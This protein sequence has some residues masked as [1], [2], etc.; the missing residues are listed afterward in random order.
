MFEIATGCALATTASDCRGLRSQLLS[1]SAPD[2]ERSLMRL[3]LIEREDLFELIQKPDL[4]IED[5]LS[6]RCHFALL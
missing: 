2:T 4:A 5:F 3:V 1:D 6:D